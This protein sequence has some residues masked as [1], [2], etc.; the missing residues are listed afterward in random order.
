MTCCICFDE[1]YLSAVY[2]ELEFAYNCKSVRSGLFF[3]CIDAVLKTWKFCAV[4]C[5]FCCIT[6]C[7]S[8]LVLAVIND[9]AFKRT[10]ISSNYES[11][12]SCCFGDISACYGLLIDSDGILLS[13]L[14]YQMSCNFI[15]VSIAVCNSCHALL[16]DLAVPDSKFK[17]CHCFISLGSSSLLKDICSVLKT[18]ELSAVAWEF[19][20]LLVSCKSLAVLTENNSAK[21]CVLCSK[22][23]LCLTCFFRYLLCTECLLINSQYRFRILYNDLI[24]VSRNITVSYSCY[25]FLDNMTFLNLKRK[26]SYRCIAVGSSSFLQWVLTVLKSVE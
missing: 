8:G 25:A 24:A 4:A 22:C 3:Q 16:I 10:L 19:N 7:N 12:L 1:R 15:D 2:L 23:E 17:L 20:C 5:E 13:V 9:N 18:C 21:V 6:T 26:C 11:C 14:Y